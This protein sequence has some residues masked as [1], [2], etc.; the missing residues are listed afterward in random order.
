MA[1]MKCPKCWK[2]DTVTI[3]Y[4]PEFNPEC[5]Y[6]RVCYNCGW[7]SRRFRTKEDALN[8]T[9]KRPERLVVER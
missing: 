9:M 2:E 8:N 5:P 3:D 6:E 7:Y 4:T 1:I